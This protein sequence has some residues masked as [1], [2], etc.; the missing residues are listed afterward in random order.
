MDKLVIWT[1]NLV[2]A[3]GTFVYAKII[4]LQLHQ[5]RIVIPFICWASL[6]KICVSKIEK[7]N[8]KYKLK[9]NK[10]VIETFINSLHAVFISISSFVF[11]F[12][13]MEEKLYENVLIISFSY[14][15]YDILKLIFYKKKT[16]INLQ[17]IF[18]HSI[19]LLNL[20][21]LFINELRIIDNYIHI[22]ALL[23]MSELSTIF[24]N[25][26]WCLK[27]TKKQDTKLFKYSGLST[28]ILFIPCRL[29]ISKYVFYIL[30]KKSYFNSYMFFNSIFLILN[31]FWFYKLI[32]NY[33]EK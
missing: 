12:K 7:F 17:L 11:L 8:I 29:F 33:F 3:Y 32:Q 18:H 1:Y 9:L 30:Y 14:L 26:S 24:L 19:V 13:Y 31:Y 5:Y 16:K 4:V 23:Y 21:P 28:I 6:E 2:L 25:L 10:S 15:F 22:T 20:I 27:E